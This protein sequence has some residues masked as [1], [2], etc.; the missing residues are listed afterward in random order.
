[1]ASARAR[2]LR[3]PSTRTR[4][5]RIPD[6]ARY[7]RSA[8]DAVLDAALVAH[9][10]FV[11]DGRPF[12]IPTL[13]ARVGDSVLVH[14]S[15]A[16]R[17]LRTLAEGVPVCLTVT[18]L[19]GI[20]LARS[21]FEHSMNYRSVVVLGTAIPVTEREEKRAA[22][23]ALTERLL[24]GRWDDARQ[25][26]AKE[27]KATAVLKLPLNEASAKIRDGGPDD[28]GTPDADLDVWAGHIPLTVAAGEPVPAP[29][30]RAG[31]PV[32]PYARRYRR[33]GLTA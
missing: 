24:P 9:L 14:G 20:V 15:A 31:I 10:G 7:D 27:L 28:D 32:P 25:P 18:L 22:L 2:A 30:L 4:V 1:M 6:R 26:T 17:S 8:I 3:A 16:A 19:D 11:H 33:P 5:R 13:H 12:V 29:G 23:H 21:V